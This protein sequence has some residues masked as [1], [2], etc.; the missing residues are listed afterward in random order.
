VS[1]ANKIEVA[2]YNTTLGKSLMYKRNISGPTTDPRGTPYL[3]IVHLEVIFK[4]EVELLSCT[5]DIY[6][7]NKILTMTLHSLLFHSRGVIFINNEWSTESKAF[8]ISKKI[9]PT[10]VWLF[11]AFRISGVNLNI[12]SSVEY[13]FL[14]LNC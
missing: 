10:N 6:L 4:L 13:L 2:L 9:L 14:K 1:S 8:A 5:F 12:S 11:K 3:T 7:I